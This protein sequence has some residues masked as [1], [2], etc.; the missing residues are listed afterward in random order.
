MGALA[1]IPFYLIKRK[2][3][4]SW[5][6]HVNTPLFFSG[7]GMLPPATPINYSLWFMTGYAPFRNCLT[8]STFFNGW[9]MRFH[10]A[11]WV[12][13]NYILV[14][15]SGPNEAD[16]CVGRWLEYWMYDS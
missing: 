16:L 3:P 4:N 12:K 15:L 14:T 13:Y 2:W 10:Q 11:W 1:P 7:T 8:Y 5:A 6:K 9:V